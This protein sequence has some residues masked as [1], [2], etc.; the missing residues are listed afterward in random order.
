ML[1]QDQRFEL[2]R[3]LRITYRRLISFFSWKITVPV[4]HSDTCLDKAH[5]I[6][7]NYIL[8]EDRLQESQLKM[9]SFGDVPP[10][11]NM[12]AALK[13]AWIALVSC[14]LLALTAVV[15]SGCLRLP[16]S[17]DHESW[18]VVLQ[19]GQ[20]FSALAIPFHLPV[21][22]PACSL[23]KLT[24]KPLRQKSPIGIHAFL[25]ERQ[26]GHGNHQLKWEIP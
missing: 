23:H 20:E 21:L 16:S 2:H 12:V 11:R 10:S 4:K 22:E 15:Q 6:P 9:L 13:T 17:L 19:D 5:T 18:Y 26:V 3:K 7:Q 8:S 25:I 14:F 1:S 24:S